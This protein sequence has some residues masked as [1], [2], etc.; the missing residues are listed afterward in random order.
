MPT[1]DQNTPYLKYEETDILQVDL[2]PV[3]W[4]IQKNHGLDYELI[5]CIWTEFSILL[6]GN[7]CL[8][9]QNYT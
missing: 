9:Q 8:E 4:T 2:K 3:L 5:M 6:T 7:N 1:I